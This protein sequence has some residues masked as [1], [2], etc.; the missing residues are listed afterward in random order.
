MTR[1]CTGSGLWKVDHGN[2][3]IL[4][5]SSNLILLDKGLL[6]Y[7]LW[8]MGGRR[9]YLSIHMAIVLGLGARIEKSMRILNPQRRIKL[10]SNILQDPRNEK[11]KRKSA[12]AERVIVI[13]DHNVKNDLP[14]VELLASKSDMNEPSN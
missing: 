10:E 2:W 14:Y 12:K 9:G 11:N 13:G 3:H 4:F 6:S 8:T 7:I 5:H 1:S